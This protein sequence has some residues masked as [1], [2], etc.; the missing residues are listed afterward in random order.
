M[1]R[2]GNTWRLF[3]EGVQAGLCVARVVRP[4][5]AVAEGEVAAVVGAFPVRNVLGDP[6]PALV[7]ISGIPVF[8]VPTAMEV[9]GAV[10]AGIRPRHLDAVKIDFLIALETVVVSFFDFRN[11]H[12]TLVL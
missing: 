11:I 8:A 7:V 3:E 6:L 5:F 4:G 9:M 1:L 2:M 10:G 12:S